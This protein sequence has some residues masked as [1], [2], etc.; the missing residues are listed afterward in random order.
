MQTKALERVSALGLR[1]RHTNHLDSPRH[2]QRDG[3]D[4]RQA[5]LYVV[6]GAALCGRRA[7]YIEN[8]LRDALNVLH[9]LARVHATLK[10]VAGIG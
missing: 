2:A 10:A 4:R 1:Q 6:N 7:A 5:D 8:Q 9:S 3:H